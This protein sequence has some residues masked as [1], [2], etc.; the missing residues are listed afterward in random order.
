M[1]SSSYSFFFPPL[2]FIVVSIVTPF[3]S[4]NAFWIAETAP[5]TPAP[6]PDGSLL[7]CLHPL[8]RVRWAGSSVGSLSCN[9]PGRTF[10]FARQKPLCPCRN[11]PPPFLSPISHPFFRRSPL[12]IRVDP[13]ERNLFFALADVVS[14]QPPSFLLPVRMGARFAP[15]LPPESLWNV[16]SCRASFLRWARPS[17]AACSAFFSADSGLTPSQGADLFGW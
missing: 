9:K 11:V 3:F 5:Q 4:S 2:Q 1:H 17:R 8:L 12:L 7:V 6:V 16:D 13:L 14:P 15:R 10:A